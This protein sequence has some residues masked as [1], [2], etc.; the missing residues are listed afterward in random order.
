MENTIWYDGA[1]RQFTRVVLILTCAA[2][3]CAEQVLI[4]YSADVDEDEEKAAEKLKSAAE[5]SNSAVAKKKAAG[6]AK[7][8]LHPSVASLIEFITN[9]KAMDE[10]MVQVRKC[11]LL[12]PHGLLSSSPHG[13][14]IVRPPVSRSSTMT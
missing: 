10:A 11:L 1:T 3:S 5:S 8:T 2:V 14:S 13:P 12:V 4:D 9:K 6:P 7:C